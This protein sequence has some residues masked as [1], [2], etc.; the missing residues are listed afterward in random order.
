VIVGVSETSR[1]LPALRQALAL[2]R[3]NAAL[4]IA[5]HAWTPP[6]GDIA[7]RRA[8]CAEL[9]RVWKREAGARLADALDLAWGG[10]APDGV[11]VR[12]LVQRGEARRVLVQTAWSPDDLLVIGTGRPGWLGRALGGWVRRYC[13]AHAACPVLT[14]PPP[15]LPKGGGHGVACWHRHLTMADALREWGHHPAT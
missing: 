3:T 8:P 4:L 10:R 14:V 1:S 12:T 5:V 13:V 7:E 2:A 9:R 11:T 15:A 6:G